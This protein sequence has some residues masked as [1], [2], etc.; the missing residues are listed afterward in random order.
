[1]ATMQQNVQPGQG[2]T[3]GIGS[4]ITNDAYN[5]ISALHA[6]LEGLEAYRKY[7][8]DANSQLWQQLTQVE[9]QVVSKLVE[10]LERLVK[11][12]KLRMKEPGRA[13]G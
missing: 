9:I 7:S 6:K 10:E 12:G 11:D 8:K 13:N 2:Q 5:V 3:Q 1:M 4:P